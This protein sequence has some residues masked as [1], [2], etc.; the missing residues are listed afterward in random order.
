MVA[1]ETVWRDRCLGGAGAST[2][3]LGLAQVCHLHVVFVNSQCHYSS[4]S[5]RLWTEG[6]VQGLVLL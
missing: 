1:S 5:A 6:V 2:G 3:L 4:V